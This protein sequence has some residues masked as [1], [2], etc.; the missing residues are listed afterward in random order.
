[1]TQ[2]WN[3]VTSGTLTVGTYAA[4]P[5]KRGAATNWKVT[6]LPSASAVR[7]TVDGQP[8]TR[9]DVIGPNTIRIDATIDSR[10]YRIVTGY[11]GA[12]QRADD[13][14]R[15]EQRRAAPKLAAAAP[16]AA[17]VTSTVALGYMRAK[18]STLAGSK[19]RADHL[20]SMAVRLFPRGAQ[21][22]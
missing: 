2:A 12:G 7:I 5:D 8:F 22:K 13:R 15:E 9:S 3:D 4:S 10:Q 1:M 21:I 18:T 6:N 17:A 20:H 19:S 14:L 16:L 11:R